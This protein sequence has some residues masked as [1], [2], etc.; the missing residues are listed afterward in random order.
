MLTLR[1][2]LSIILILAGSIYSVLVLLY[3]EITVGT[4]CFMC[5]EKLYIPP[6]TPDAPFY[7]VH[8]FLIPFSGGTAILVSGIFLFFF[9]RAN[10]K[11]SAH[12]ERNVS[13]TDREVS[14]G[15]I[16]QG[17]LDKTDT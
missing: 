6:I 15:S 1:R 11:Q 8:P 17:I 9:P 14:N 12:A 13:Q 3:S 7:Q 4:T 2:L 16:E 10:S 5:G